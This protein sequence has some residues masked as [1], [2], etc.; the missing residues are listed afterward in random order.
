MTCNVVATFSCVAYRQAGERG[1]L[2]ELHLPFAETSWSTG[3]LEQE[4]GEDD[5]G[6]Q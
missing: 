1:A 2:I 5:G 4:L 6:E 3:Q